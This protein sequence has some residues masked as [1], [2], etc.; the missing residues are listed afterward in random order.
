VLR[1]AI[2]KTPITPFL[3][4]NLLSGMDNG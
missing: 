4:K 1:D 2:A 3:E